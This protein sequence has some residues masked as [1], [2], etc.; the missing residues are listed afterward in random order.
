MGTR[1][2]SLD[3]GVIL[4]LLG[5]GMTAAQIESLLYKK[6]GLLG[7]S[8]VSNDVRDL[9][10]SKEPMAA[11]ALEYFVYR[12]VREI[13]A[14]TAALGGLDGVVF[15]A[16]VGENSPVI[17]KR[18]C[19][20]LGWLSIRIDESANQRGRGCISPPGASPQVWVIPTDEEIVIA[21]QTLEVARS[22]G[23]RP[24]L[25]TSAVP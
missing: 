15:T 7:I 25:A 1:C 2:G 4:F 18:V 9:L 13:G 8:G 11:E 12:I 19:D 23:P 16:G 6:T 24:E 21:S 5:R 17:R 22:A 3:P 14:L 10:A 20:G